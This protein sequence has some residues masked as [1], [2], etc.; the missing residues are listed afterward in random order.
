MS[1]VCRVFQLA[2]LMAAVTAPA[3]AQRGYPRVE[4]VYP[5]AVTRGTT[6]EVFLRCRY[7]V[8][9]AYRLLFDRP[10]VTAEV[11]EWQD[12][13]DPGVP[14][15]KRQPFEPEGLRISVQVARDA[16]L[17]IHPFRILTKGSL[18]ALAHLLVTDS[19]AVLEAEPNDAPR[20]A[21]KIEIPQTVNGLLDQDA[22]LDIYEFQAAAGQ[23]VTFLAWA[24]RLQHPVPHLERDFADLILSLHDDQGNELAAA[25]DGLNQ[26][27][28]LHYRFERNGTYRLHVREARYHAGKYK[29]WYALTLGDTPVVTSVYPPVVNPGGKVQLEVSGLHTGRLD[30]VVHVPARAGEMFPLPWPDAFAPVH[31]G[32]TDLPL[33]SEPASGP[34]TVSVPAGIN[35]RILLPDEVDRYRF[36]AQ[37]GERFEFDV[38]ARGLGSTLDALLELRDAN[39]R[40]LAAKDDEVN[41]VGQTADGLSFPLD[42]DP[43]LEWVAPED[44][45]YEILVRDANLF[46]GLDYTYFLSVRHQEEDFALAVDDDRMPAGPGESVTSI[47]TVERRNGFRGPVELLVEGLPEGVEALESTIP[48][49]LD[50]GNLVLTARQGAPPGASNVQVVGK[51]AV[52][53]VDGSIREIRRTA[54]PYAPMGQAGGR[55][56]FP[57]TWMAAA[58]TEASDIVMEAS[59]REIRVHPGESFTVDIRVTRSQYDGPVEMNVILWN[60]MQRFAKLPPGVFL[61][62]KRS[63]TSLG[64]GES[65]GMVTFRVAAEAPPL[66]RYLMTVLG[67]ITYNRIFMTR[68]AAP[69][70][71]T[72]LPATRPE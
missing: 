17:G 58:V 71:L 66:D 2:L 24:A 69:F 13:S 11:L 23:E 34:V 12:L 4:T 5:G 56:F 68:V 72:I 55:S 48:A 70:H 59:P 61:D 39:G 21:Q 60:L 41:T 25:D 44:G 22:D 9:E 16:P 43:R 33:T 37:A 31:L 42:K 27:P 20:Q 35:G 49:H 1:S 46:G 65:Q 30:H 6:A 10:G 14:K 62:E 40:L 26:D 63:K 45:N 3:A 7:N 32:V 54:R 19:P 18:S 57:V 52:R 38:R 28:T 50:Q 53:A 47:V 64:P 36:R 15:E 29:W 8:R 67:Q 51:A